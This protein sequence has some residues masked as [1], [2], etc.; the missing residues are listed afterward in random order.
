VRRRELIILLGSAAIAWPLAGR[1]Q[2]KTMPVVG[3]LA[4]GSP[5]PNAP[6][7]AGLTQGLRETG[8]LESQNVAIE[9]RWAEGS[10]DRLPALAADLVN[11]KVDVIVT[12]GPPATLSS[13]S[14]VG[15]QQ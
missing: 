11:R 2:Q 8:F 9:Y 7:V 4:S 12:G 3:Y 14:E 15:T 5:G 6:T 1:A 13:D 10:Y